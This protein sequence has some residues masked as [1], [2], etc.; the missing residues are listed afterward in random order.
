MRPT[1]ALVYGLAG[2]SLIFVGC[3]GDAEVSD[4]QTGGHSTVAGAGGDGNPVDGTSG[5]G[6]LGQAGSGDS[7]AGQNGVGAGGGPLGG[8]QPEAGAAGASPGPDPGQ[9]CGGSAT[10]C[11]ELTDSECPE[12]RGCHA[13]T[14]CAGE[15]LDCTSADSK[16]SCSQIQGCSWSGNCSG[17]AAACNVLT[18]SDACANNGCTW[19]VC[20]GTVSPCSSLNE[21]RCISQ[22][23]CSLL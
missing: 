15:P 17:V 1:L 11:T 5:D 19:Q 13:A 3:G 18:T 22:P 6:N 14:A 21:R 23:G 10:P 7:A 20:G 8:G 4:A 9:V 12:A 16:A 2:A